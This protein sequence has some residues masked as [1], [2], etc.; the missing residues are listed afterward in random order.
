MALR[1]LKFDSALSLRGINAGAGHAASTCRAQR[2]ASR[3][4]VARR[5][6]GFALVYS[7]MGL[8]TFLGV[9]ALV[10]DMGR[11]YTRRAQAQN[12]A[13]SAAL[14][15]SYW[16]HKGA[17]E[18]STQAKLFAEKNGYKEGSAEVT[19]RVF[20]SKGAAPGARQMDSIKVSVQRAEPLYFLP[21]F[22]A[23]I[24][25]SA[26]SSKVGA[27]ATSHATFRSVNGNPPISLG[28]DYGAT[29]GFANPSIFGR[30][31]RYSHGDA[32]SPAFLGDGTT[33]NEGS[34]SDPRGNKFQGYEYT[35]NIASGYATLNGTSQVQVEIF[36]PDSHVAKPEAM[37]DSWDEWHTGLN[38][39]FSHTT[40]TYE[41]IA[42]KKDLKDPDVVIATASYGNDPAT[43]LKWT[44]PNGFTF[45]TNTYGPG[46]YKVRVKAGS[47]TTENG[48]Q[49]RAGKPHAGL[50]EP[51][52]NADWK[53]QYNY[54]GT[55]NGTS[56]TAQGK[57]V[58]N[59]T[60]NEGFVELNLGFVPKEA[61]DV[62]VDK[63]DTD[64]GFVSIEY[65][66]K[67]PGPNGTY[68]DIPGYTKFATGQQARDGQW[69]PTDVIPVPSGYPTEG[70]YW[71]AT[72]K[73]GA[74]D[75]SNWKMGYAD[76]SKPS[77]DPPSVKLVD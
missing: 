39:S 58:L 61:T 56:F 68:V 65:S 4:R 55:G 60:K 7:A 62:F 37:I 67:K 12:A 30:E 3:R 15:G 25:Q 75:T 74:Y 41:L 43:N 21:A 31:G 48:F 26:S 8:A 54:N 38:G 5:R 24:G 57:A 44:T 16:L 72:Y 53:T 27:S 70:A 29:D 47:G 32:Y 64:V 9:T 23:L 59:F 22:A 17:E 2:R 34:D 46:A 40:T 10:V 6:G 45:D 52:D 69:A 20:M 14:A 42:P 13:D 73:A 36:D 63:F 51:T 49:F 35:L 11:L 77:V 71:F 28:A 50:R 76:P 33:P 66:L 18:A 19:V 1:F